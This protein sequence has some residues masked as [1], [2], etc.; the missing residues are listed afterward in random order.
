MWKRRKGTLVQRKRRKGTLV[1]MQLNILYLYRLNS[2]SS[3]EAAYQLTKE[4]VTP[5]NRATL[6]PVYPN[7]LTAS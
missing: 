1:Q 6:A 3:P 7:F 5:N 2:R 4:V